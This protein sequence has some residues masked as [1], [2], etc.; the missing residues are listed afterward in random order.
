MAASTA[1][2]MPPSRR[3]SPGLELAL[4]QQLAREAHAQWA[5]Q[6]ALVL[7]GGAVVAGLAAGIEARLREGLRFRRHW[8]GFGGAD[9]G[10]RVSPALAYLLVCG[11]LAVVALMLTMEA[12][13]VTEEPYR[14]A[15]EPATEPAT[16]SGHEPAVRK[17]V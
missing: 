8:G 11:V 1:A 17:K 10:W 15:D 2:G 5:R 16:G 9:S 14:V 13:R 6:L 12:A 3:S 7:G 4:R